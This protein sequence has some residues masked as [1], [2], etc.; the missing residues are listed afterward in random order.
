MNCPSRTDEPEGP[1]K[2]Q[3]PNFLAADLTT[4]EDLNGI[5]NSRL[6]RREVSD[7]I[8]HAQEDGYPQD[9]TVKIPALAKVSKSGDDS[10]VPEFTLAAGNGNTGGGS[11][12][13]SGGTNGVD[14]SKP[15]FLKLR[16]MIIT[17]GKFIGPGF[18]VRSSRTHHVY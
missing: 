14:S 9:S 11:G 7:E 2:N 18:M 5:S 13:G 12:G 4:R 6:L 17:F 3:Q 1:G 8:Q 16:D 15:I 10:H